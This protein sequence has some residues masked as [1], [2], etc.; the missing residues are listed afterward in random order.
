MRVSVEVTEEMR[1]EA[2]S[3]GLPVMEYVEKLI[4]R[5]RQAGHDAAVVSNAIERIRA[6]RAGAKNS[7]P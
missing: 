2:E 1:R 6:L 7:G 4:A 5:G 3:Q